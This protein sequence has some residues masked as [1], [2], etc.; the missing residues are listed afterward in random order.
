MKQVKKIF[1]KRDATVYTR[2]WILKRGTAVI[3]MTW[4]VGLRKEGQ[5][6]EGIGQVDFLPLMVLEGVV[7]TVLHVV[8]VANTSAH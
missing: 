7:E 5:W 8:R 3:A 4:P 1:R 6:K 2:I